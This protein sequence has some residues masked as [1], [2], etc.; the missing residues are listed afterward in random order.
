V[1]TEVPIANTKVSD[2]ALNK[3]QWDKEGKRVSIGS[4]DGRVH[5]Y[6]IGEVML[7]T[8]LVTFFSKKKFLLKIFL[9]EFCSY[10]IHVKR[11]GILCKQSY[12]K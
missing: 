12:Q 10:V 6:D 1:D 5:V 4:S 2:R 3:I 8:L 7:D 9:I 11:N